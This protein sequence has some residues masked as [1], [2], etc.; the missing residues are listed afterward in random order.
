LGRKTLPTPSEAHLF[1]SGGLQANRVHWYFQQFRDALLHRLAV[2]LQTWGFCQQ[3][4]V[5]IAHHVAAR[6]HQ[7]KTVRDELVTGSAPPLWIRVRK[8]L[9]NIAKG[10][11]AKQGVAQ[12]VQENVAVRVRD[13]AMAVRH[14]Y[15]GQP[16]MVARAES[17][18][19][20]A[21]PDPWAQV[22]TQR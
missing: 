22:S 15:A 10:H 2:R 4:E 8:M 1:G 11:S 3:G 16:H 19:V 13:D 20:E 9:A 14:A 17:V 5:R 12:G 6:A 18:Y 21:K 7:P